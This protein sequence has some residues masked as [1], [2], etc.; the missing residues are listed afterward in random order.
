MQKFG[1][2]KDTASFVGD[3][4]PAILNED[5]FWP[6]EP[7]SIQEAGLPELLLE[8]LICQQLI[9]AGTLSGRNWQKESAYH[10]QSSNSC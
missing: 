9:N 2:K 4:L 5:S 10:T 1:S 7:R 3:V 6:A 8:S